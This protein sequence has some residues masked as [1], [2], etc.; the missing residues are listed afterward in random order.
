MSGRDPA[1]T[2]NEPDLRNVDFRKW[3]DRLHWQYVMRRLGEDR[4]GT[5][6]WAPAGTET[7]RGHE[8]PELSR[9]AFLHLFPHEDWWSVIWNAA[10]KYEVY[11]D[12]N[13]PPR[14]NGAT[15]TMVDLDLDVVRY[16]ADGA[17]AVLDEDE[18]LEH[19]TGYP[20]HVID[21]ARTA[22]ARIALRLEH[23]EEPF[24]TAG[25]TRLADALRR[26]G[27]TSVS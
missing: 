21:A 13:T 1:A 15:V 6:L 16:R 18:F 10:G 7:R 14:W 24:T 27:D 9:H 2:S 26:F 12:I 22:A 4:H 25:P 23:N 17:V 19:S 5:W 3:P 20:P 11:V 8:P